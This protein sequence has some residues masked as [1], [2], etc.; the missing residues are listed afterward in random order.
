M[1][2]QDLL[3]LLASSPS[4]QKDSQARSADLILPTPQTLSSVKGYGLTL[5]Q[6]ALSFPI[7]TIN[8]DLCSPDLLLNPLPISLLKNAH[9]NRFSN[10]VSIA[11]NHTFIAYAVK[12]IFV[13]CLAHLEK[14]SWKN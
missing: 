7:T 8:A 2:K 4:V 14:H 13:F 9:P 5:N 12:G 11:V 6:N 1:D 10:S 3:A